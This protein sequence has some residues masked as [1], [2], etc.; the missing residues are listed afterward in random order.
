MFINQSELFKGLDKQFVRKLMEVSKKEVYKKRTFLFAEGDPANYFYV[1]LKGHIKLIAGS[2][3]VDVFET[4][5]AGD[6]FGWSGLVARERY[7][8]SCE[9]L[10]DT[11]LVR[12]AVKDILEVA[13][14]D[15]AQGMVFFRMLANMLGDR[16]TQLYKIIN[17]AL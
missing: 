15:P 8:T 3:L 6:A 16:L 9:C 1:F 2:Q 17:S 4:K 14:A 5:R 11:T 13:A 12:F 10:E 7:T